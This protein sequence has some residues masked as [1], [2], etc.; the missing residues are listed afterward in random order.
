[1]KMVPTSMNLSGQRSNN[2]FK[3]LPED[4]F[5]ASENISHV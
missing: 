2:R 1:M 3:H 5:I 4:T